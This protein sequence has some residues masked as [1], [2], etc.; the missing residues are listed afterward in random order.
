MPA[1]RDQ[2]VA[3]LAQGAVTEAPGVGRLEDQILDP[4]GALPIGDDRLAAGDHRL[5]RRQQDRVVGIA[6][7]ERGEVVAAQRFDER[8]VEP[9]EPG[10]IVVGRHLKLRS[11]QPVFA[12]HPL[13]RAPSGPDASHR[14]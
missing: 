2:Q 7:A 4:I 14:P 9:L 10:G 11:L 6:G 12:E 3:G 13:F 1:R 8:L 5:A